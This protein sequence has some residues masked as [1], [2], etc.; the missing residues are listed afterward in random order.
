MEA[1]EAKAL[2]THNDAVDEAGGETVDGAANDAAAAVGEAPAVEAAAAAEAEAEA[3]SPP[4][5]AEQ[6]PLAD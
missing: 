1:A 5:A 3:V 6:P 2:A 4:A